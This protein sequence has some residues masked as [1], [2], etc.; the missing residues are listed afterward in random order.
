MSERQAKVGK[1]LK[2]LTA[3]FIQLEANTD[4]LITITRVDISPDLKRA[5]IFFTTI[6]D[7]KEAAALIFM[8][9]CGS[10]LRKYIKSK[11]SMKRIPHFDFMVDAGERH[12]QHIDEVMRD[13]DTGKSE[14]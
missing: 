7:G 3:T 9:R 12:R 10:E 11:A 1:L 6:P 8:K 14:Q 4:P 2:E 13:I 5:I